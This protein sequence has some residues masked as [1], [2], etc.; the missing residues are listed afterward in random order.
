MNSWSSIGGNINLLWERFL[1]YYILRRSFGILWGELLWEDV[2]FSTSHLGQMVFYEKPNRSSM[3]N[4]LG[5]IRE[6][7]LVFCEKTL[8]SCW[9]KHVCLFC[10]LSSMGSP[11]VLQWEDLL[12]FFVK[13]F[14]FLWSSYPSSINR[15][16]RSLMVFYKKTFWPITT[17]QNGLIWKNVLV[18]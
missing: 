2:Y 15:S 11:F 6:V 18:F 8:L 7:L 1:T 13:T 3:R 16:L 12:D 4:Q 10:D 14:Q 9:T 5:L 17:I